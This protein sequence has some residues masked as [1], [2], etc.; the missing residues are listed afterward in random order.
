MFRPSFWVPGFS[1]P[2]ILRTGHRG[3]AVTGPDPFRTEGPS[4]QDA[5]VRPNHFLVL[6]HKVGL[7]PKRN[8]GWG[9]SGNFTF[10][11]RDL[12]FLDLFTYS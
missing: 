10:I 8:E 1:V 3:W 5:L 7:R 6:E 9:P 4:G 12:L 2:V 11:S